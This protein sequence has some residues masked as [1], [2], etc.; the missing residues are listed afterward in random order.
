MQIRHDSD[1]LATQTSTVLMLKLVALCRHAV[2]LRL[3]IT[4]RTTDTHKSSRGSSCEETAGIFLSEWT[5]ATGV[6]CSSLTRWT[7]AVSL[8]WHGWGVLLAYWAGCHFC[9]VWLADDFL[10]P[11]KT[12]G[13]TYQTTRCHNEGYYNLN[14]CHCENLK[15]YWDYSC[16]FLV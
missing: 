10:A 9:D 8:Q 13:S 7:A 3:L 16:A 6:Q 2:K 15:F 14:L 4:N 1:D 11:S 5:G 12:L